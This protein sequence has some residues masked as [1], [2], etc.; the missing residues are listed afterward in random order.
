MIPLQKKGRGDEVIQVVFDSDCCVFWFFILRTIFT[1]H[2]P[3]IVAL[4]EP[5]VSVRQPVA[6]AQ[7][8]VTVEVSHA[9]Y[10]CLIAGRTVYSSVQCTNAIVVDNHMTVISPVATALFPQAVAHQDIAVPSFVTNEPV[11]RTDCKPEELAVEQ[12][13][14]ALRMCTPMQ[15]EFL[16]QRLRDANAALDACQ[17][18]LR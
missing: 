12:S 17:F 4:F 2:F 10:K 9:T 7:P 6:T 3:Q 16:R 11:K 15:C 18:S 1:L 8:D 5:T 14:I 13:H